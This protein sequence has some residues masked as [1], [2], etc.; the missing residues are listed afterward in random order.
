MDRDG[1]GRAVV[2]VRIV[3]SEDL[4][5][6]RSR[7]VTDIRSLLQ[8]NFRLDL[9]DWL[10][11]EIDKK[12]TEKRDRKNIYRSI[13]CVNGLESERKKKQKK[14]LVIR[15]FVC[16]VCSLTEN[17]EL[18]TRIQPRLPVTAKYR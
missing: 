10:I 9:I 4:S 8:L 11:A 5:W 18:C 3:E 13:I 17:I 7:V 1:G 6:I 12:E 16:T 14:L 15:K 2:G